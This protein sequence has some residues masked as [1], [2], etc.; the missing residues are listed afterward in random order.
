VRLPF[1]DDLRDLTLR[2]TNLGFLMNQHPQEI[3][4]RKN[5]VESAKRVVDALTEPHWEPDMLDNPALKVCY[6]GIEAIALSIPADQTVEVEDLLHPDPRKVEIAESLAS[7]WLSSMHV[8]DT[9]ACAAAGSV[10][11]KKIKTEEKKNLDRN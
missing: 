3:E 10:V 11:A 1:A 9:S 8:I 5:Q 7:Q 6:T 2:E 4:V